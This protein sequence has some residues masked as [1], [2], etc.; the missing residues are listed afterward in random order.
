MAIRIVS[1][2]KDLGAL[3]YHKCGIVSFLVLFSYLRRPQFSHS[4]IDGH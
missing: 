2:L 1:H 4:H 3:Q